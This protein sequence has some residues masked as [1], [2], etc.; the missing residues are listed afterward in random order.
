[1]PLKKRQEG[2]ACW[3]TGKIWIILRNK[4]RSR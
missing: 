1:M 4:E 2:D 3:Q